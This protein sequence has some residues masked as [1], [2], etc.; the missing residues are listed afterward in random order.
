MNSNQSYSIR[1]SSRAKRVFLKI[2]ARYGLEV[3]IP[4]G[5]D[6]KA[7]P[8]IIK[9]QRGWIDRT[10]KKLEERGKL[11]DQP[12]ELPTSIYFPSLNQHF[13]VDYHQLS[14]DTLK[15]TQVSNSQINI[16]SDDH[17]IA[18]CTDLLKR[19]L[20]YQ[21]RR[22]LIPWL[23][24]V[25]QQTGILYTKVQIR[26]QKTRWG[27]CSKLGAISLNYNLLFLPSE[28]V[29]YVMLHELCHTIHLNHSEK[30][31]ALMARFAPNHKALQV[32]M[33]DVWKYIPWWAR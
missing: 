6:R 23:T 20:Q 30:F 29:E 9:A 24:R 13:R 7:I 27:S 19:W 26:G 16:T 32:E 18:G 4:T 22:H 11:Y 5:F 15:L 17:N 14:G 12:H 2:S 25:S 10:F 21:G 1:E 28:L 31:Y 33:R 3:V 8:Q